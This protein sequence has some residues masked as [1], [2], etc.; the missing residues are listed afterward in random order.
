[1]K[2]LIIKLLHGAYCE[3]GALIVRFTAILWWGVRKPGGSRQRAQQQ[4]IKGREHR[5]GGWVARF[6]AQLCRLILGKPRNFSE[7]QFSH[8]QNRGDDPAACLF[9][10]FSREKV[11]VGTLHLVKPHACDSCW[12]GQEHS[13]NGRAWGGGL[14][15]QSR[16]D[17]GRSWRRLAVGP[18]DHRGGPV[19]VSQLP[20]DT[21]GLLALR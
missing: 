19:A 11:P 2:E 3:P 10:R 17:M 5:P 6:N 14:C 12:E 8:L 4:R 1:M 21:Q 15:Q 7:S 16:G 13:K 20:E 18:Q 9:G